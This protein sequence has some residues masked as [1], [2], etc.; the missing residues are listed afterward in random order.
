M[1]EEFLKITNQNWKEFIIEYDI[2]HKDDIN[3]SRLKYFDEILLIT[4]IPYYLKL[5]ILIFNYPI[6][7][8]NQHASMNAYICL[9]RAK[10][11]ITYMML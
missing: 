9:P 4:I 5:Q 1:S 6:F 7:R 2:L 8:N 3:N 10:T 11:R